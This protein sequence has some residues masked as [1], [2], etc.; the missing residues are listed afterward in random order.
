[1]WE[2]A[3]DQEEM[4]SG[5]TSGAVDLGNGTPTGTWYVQGHQ[6]DRYLY[7]ASGGAY[8]VHYWLPY[9][10]DY[11]MHDSPWQKFHYGSALYRT[12][13]SHGCIHVP[14]VVMRFTYY[15]AQTGTMVSIR[16]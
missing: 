8:F 13:G 1:M 4:T 15:W 5:I 16:A 11:G 14:P 3:A 7:P 6:R 9:N 12:Q 10:Y 2:C